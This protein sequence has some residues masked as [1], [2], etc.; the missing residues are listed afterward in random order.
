MSLC[1]Q[2]RPCLRMLTLLDLS[3]PPY[4]LNNGTVWGLIVLLIV[5]IFLVKG[6]STTLCA[7]LSGLQW[8]QAMCVG[9]LMQSKGE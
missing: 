9:A 7:K 1:A 2:R 4:S 8:R 6:A 3:H 5:V